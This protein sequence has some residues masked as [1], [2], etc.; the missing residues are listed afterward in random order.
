MPTVPGLLTRAKRWLDDLP[1]ENLFTI[2]DF[3]HFEQRLGAWVGPQEYGH[4]A[5]RFAVSPFCHRR[6]VQLKLTLPIEYRRRDRLAT[7]LLKIRWPELLE[8]PFNGDTTMR[9]ALTLPR[10]VGAGMLSL[11]TRLPASFFSRRATRGSPSMGRGAT[12]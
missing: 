3:L 1:T 7:D 4:V 11:A 8:V 12:S 10:R 2:L 5:T 9:R 6:I